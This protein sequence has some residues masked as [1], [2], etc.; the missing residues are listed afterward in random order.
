MEWIVNNTV[1]A[2][3]VHSSFPCS[4]FLCQILHSLSMTVIGPSLP[5]V[6]EFMHPNG[7]NIQSRYVVMLMIQ[8]FVVLPIQVFPPCFH[9]KAKYLNKLLGNHEVLECREKKRER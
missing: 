2:A 9:Y 6:R 7:G 1:S 3:M 4:T 8:S 5:F